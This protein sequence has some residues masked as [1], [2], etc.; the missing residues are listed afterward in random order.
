MNVELI[1]QTV[2]AGVG[3]ISTNV[4]G[5]GQLACNKWLL[6]VAASAGENDDDNITL[7]IRPERLITPGFY[8]ITGRLS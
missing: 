5:E 6:I 1:Q 7:A 3:A 4:V 2:K 8:T